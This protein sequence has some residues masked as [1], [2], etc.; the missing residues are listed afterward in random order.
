MLVIVV[1]EK[2]H[3]RHL[4]GLTRCSQ[5]KEDDSVYLQVNQQ[6]T[7]AESAFWSIFLNGDCQSAAVRTTNPESERALAAEVASTRSM[8]SGSSTETV[9]YLLKY[10]A[11]H[12]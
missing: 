7:A 4:F 6:R 8:Q 10:S 9:K 1:H 11:T 5:K 12:N 2:N 3:F